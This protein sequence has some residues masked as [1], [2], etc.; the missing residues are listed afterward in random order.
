MPKSALEQ[1]RLFL[2]KVLEELG[3]RQ[4]DSTTEHKQNMATA[5]IVLDRLDC[6]NENLKLKKFLRELVLLVAEKDAFC[7]KIVAVAEARLQENK[8]KDG[9]PQDLVDPDQIF[10]AKMDQRELSSKE[11]ANE[12]QQLLWGD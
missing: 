11:M 3:K 4:R 12:K 2:A 7:V 9:L 8:W 1:P 6:V 5:Y 10:E